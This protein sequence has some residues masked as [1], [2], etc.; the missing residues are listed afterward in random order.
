MESI[1]DLIFML[2]ILVQ[3]NSSYQDSKSDYV[4]NRCKIAKRYLLGWFFIDFLAV[5][6]RFFNL[7]PMNDDQNDLDFLGLAKFARISRVIKLMRLFRVLKF[8]KA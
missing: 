5:M 4:L 1:T 6:P 7:I 3:F 8:V 2:E